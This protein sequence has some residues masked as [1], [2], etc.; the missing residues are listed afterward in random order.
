M[1]DLVAALKDGDSGVA[2]GL[3]VDG[4]EESV[5]RIREIAV[6][7]GGRNLRFVKAGNDSGID[8]IR[9][10]HDGVP[11]VERVGKRHA[12]GA[13]V[14]DAVIEI[15]GDG[16]C[17]F[18]PGEGRA[19]AGVGLVVR[20]GVGPAAEGAFDVTGVV[21]ASGGGCFPMPRGDLMLIPTNSRAGNANASPSPWRWLAG[22]TC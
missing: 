20:A 17:I 5:E 3:S 15:E 10:G 2:A 14:V 12:A 4:R 13:T 18:Q 7:S 19:V 16:A 22:L 6:A 8:A 9:L 11:G 21:E 1:D